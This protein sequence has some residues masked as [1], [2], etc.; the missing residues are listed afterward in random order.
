[1]FFDGFG[2]FDEGRVEGFDFAFDEVGEKTAESDE[3]VGLGGGGEFGATFV[4][5]AIEPKAVFAEEFLG[6][7][8][9]L[10]VA[11]EFDEARKVEVVVAGGVGAAAFFDLERF[12]EFGDEIREIHESILS[13]KCWCF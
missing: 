11:G 1:M 5:V 12:E 7:L 4:L 8:G 13:W 6:D 2:E 9:G 3:V 10:E